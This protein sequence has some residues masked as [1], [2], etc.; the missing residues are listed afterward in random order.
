[1]GSLFGGKDRGTTT[2]YQAMKAA[3]ASK[4][5]AMSAEARG[6][7]MRHGISSTFNRNGESGG[8]SATSGT[9]TKLGK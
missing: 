4:E 2:S 5:S 7:E 6:K 8:N 1:M 3:P 9:A